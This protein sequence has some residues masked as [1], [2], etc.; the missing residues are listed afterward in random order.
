MTDAIWVPIPWALRADFASEYFCPTTPLSAEATP[1][2][3][4][5]ATAAE[6]NAPT[7]A[8]KILFT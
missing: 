3:S 8:T 1:P 5:N 6:P 4:V 7:P 2:P